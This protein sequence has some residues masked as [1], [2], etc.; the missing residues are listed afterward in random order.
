LPDIQL[1]PLPR[2]PQVIVLAGDFRQILPVVRRG[3]RAQIV[4]AALKRCDLWGSLH[5]MSLL[6]NQRVA[7]LR[8]GAMAAAADE[9][10]RWAEYLL[11]VGDGSLG[12]E[13]ELEDDMRVPGSDVRALIADIFG[14]LQDDE[15]RTPQ[16]LMSRCILTPK[17]ENVDAINNLIMEMLPT[18]HPSENRVYLSAD[19]MAA[20]DKMHE[21]YGTEFLN[22]LQPQGIPSH[23]IRLKVG[24][25]IM[26]LRNINFSLGLTN[27]TRLM[28]EQLG[29]RVIKARIISGADHTLG[30]SVLIPRIPLCHDDP[31]QPVL[32]TRRQLPLRPAFAMSI[33]K[34]QGQTFDKV[35]IYLPQPVFTHGQLYVALSRVGCRAGVRVMALRDGVATDRT[36][37]VVYREIFNG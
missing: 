3:S 26:L 27:G 2:L 36:A 37:D 4:D 30:S 15:R 16:A 32:F 34:A 33:N 6:E 9:L 21:L 19:Y 23:D 14:D 22:S 31:S 5:K 11:K 7:R 24:S 12:D 13:I 18:Q 25:P 28:V 10:A 8:L 17:N 35:G 1:S 29:A 20:D